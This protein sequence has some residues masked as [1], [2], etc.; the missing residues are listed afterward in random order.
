MTD[1]L[2]LLIVSAQ[3]RHAEDISGKGDPVPAV[4]ARIGRLRRRRRYAM[5]STAALVALM[6]MGGAAVAVRQFASDEDPSPI[7]KPLATPSQKPTANVP[8]T[9]DDV[10]RTQLAASTK[11]RLQMI[12]TDTPRGQVLCG[13]KVLGS[14]DA[15]RTLYVWLLCENFITGSGTATIG[16]GGSQAAVLNVSGRGKD[17]RVDEVTFARQAHLEADIHRLFPAS[18]ADQVISGNI[19]TAPSERQLKQEAARTE[20]VEPQPNPDPDGIGARFLA[21]ARGQIDSLPVDT[22]VRLYLG[23]K[24]QKTISAA[25]ANDPGALDLCTSY[26]A[27]SCPMSALT[28]LREFA[29]QPA[30]TGSLPSTCLDTLA[31]KPTDTGGNHTVVLGMPE[32]ATCA[33]DFAVQIWSNDVGQITAVNLL[34]GSP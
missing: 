15:G 33:D 2:E 4:L 26:A 6:I 11:V 29:H 17:I 19:R 30:V 27:R 13:I 23:N 9:R 34:F 24:Y 8:Q 25:R 5:A 16:S 14:S 28:T 1:D 3:R 18:L 21:F 12:G 32:P 22:P 20:S 31:N 7:Q 10:L